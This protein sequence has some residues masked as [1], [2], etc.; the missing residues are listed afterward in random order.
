M[1]YSEKKFR[2]KSD[3]V[4]Q[5]Y[6]NNVYLRIGIRVDH[7]AEAGVL[8]IWPKGN[9]SRVH[10]HAG[11]AGAIRVVRGAL[12]IYIY[13]SLTCPDPARSVILK[14]GDITWLT[15]RHNFVHKVEANSEYCDAS[16][17]EFC[18][19]FHLYKNCQ[20][21]F[22][23]TQNQGAVEKNLPKNDIEPDEWCAISEE[24]WNIYVQ[25]KKPGFFTEG[26]FLFQN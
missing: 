9:T 11:C 14:E 22:F 4:P 25:S 1:E 7:I 18:S 24:I 19:S 20:D 23:A 5:K 12:N 8:E 16:G 10:A 13:P 3:S 21:E 2:E 6:I 26:L 17:V 15:R